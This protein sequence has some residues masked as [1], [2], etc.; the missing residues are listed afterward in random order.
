M[1]WL[2]NKYYRFI[3]W[4][5][6]T[7]SEL[8][9]NRSFFGTLFSLSIRGAVIAI[10][11]IALLVA[12]DMLYMLF[13]SLLFESSSDS[14]MCRMAL[15]FADLNYRFHIWNLDYFADALSI[16]AGVLGVLL[17]LFYTAFLTIV[18]TKYSNINTV[19]SVQL[20]EQKTLNKYFTLLS[21]ITAL[22]FIF[23]FLLSFG[24]QPSIVSS[25]LYACVIVFTIASFTN[26]GRTLHIYFDPS[27]LAIDILSDCYHSLNK[28]IKHKVTLSKVE[29]GKSYIGR[30]YNQIDKI[31]TIIEESRN[32]Q[33][34][35]TS[36]HIIS[37]Q[38]GKF[39]RYLLSQKHK[40]PSDKNW[41][42]EIV[43]HKSWEDAKEWDFDLMRSTGVDILRENV[44]S[45]FE[46]ERK[47]IETQFL[48][49]GNYV[50]SSEKLN[51]VLQEVNFIR[52][53][54]F[55]C[56]DDVFELY[57][58]KLESFLLDK[59]SGQD[60]IAYCLQLASLYPHLAIHYLVGFNYYV[61]NFNAEQLKRAAHAIHN[62]RNTDGFHIPYFI[63]TTGKEYQEK[64]RKEKVIEGSI[65]T[66]LF[67]S[68]FEIGHVM[69]YSLQRHFEFVVKHF[70]SGTTRIVNT[71][72]KEHP[73]Y[74]LMISMDS[75]EL[76]RKMIL[77]TKNLNTAFESFNK[78]NFQKADAPFEFK[79]FDAVL[80]LCGEFNEIIVDC[81][82][83]TGISAYDL[84]N[85][86][87]PDIFGKY[88]QIIM[89]DLVNRLFEVP[90]NPTS[91]KDKV[92]QYLKNCSLYIY[93]L[94]NKYSS[95][96]SVDFFALRL[97]PVIMDLFEIQSIIFIVSKSQKS[98][99]L[100]DAI[101]QY[102]NDQHKSNEEEIEF[103]K[104]LYTVYSYCKSPRFALSTNSYIKEHERNMHLLEYLTR[105]KIFVE[106]SVKES[107]LFPIVKRTVSTVDDYYLN[108]I[109]SSV[110]RESFT[111][112]ELDEVFI[113]IFL[114][115]RIALKELNIKET[116]YG[117]RIK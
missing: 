73:R 27:S 38:L 21:S 7:A 55:Q 92:L 111:S 58:E 102:W 28:A 30:I 53:L 89:D 80:K 71:L 82:W 19:I 1:K 22:S 43:K 65:K 47:I 51:V 32:P 16:G 5:S 31:E 44:T 20:L 99:V 106:E 49:F 116:R 46:I 52:Q 88:Y 8:Q 87:L 96:K 41:H 68:E 66:Q 39:T 29:L 98:E 95:S 97:Y 112:I 26:Y 76:Q 42:I 81:V 13:V 94:R 62:F 36:L 109:A 61:E 10:L 37:G 74:A 115:G 104:F 77:F 78:L 70:I 24:Y 75:I 33:V 6:G 84:K 64:L 63:V 40:I 105:H 23:Q 69:Q 9:V 108:A 101:H 35:N 48:L 17:G 91:F 34:S 57:F 103:W 50:N 60:D 110:H 12:G 3:L 85:K 45:Y 59:L 93:A 15:F 117:Q 90:F 79:S 114:R 72:K 107:R 100:P 83:A 14:F 86:D 113:E 54:P 4:A 25:L 18:A 56:E 67:Y 2:K 11:G